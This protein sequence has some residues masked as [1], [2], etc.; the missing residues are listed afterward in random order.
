MDMT[1]ILVLHYYPNMN[2]RTAPNYGT[3]NVV[4][5][6]E[7]VVA[8]CIKRSLSQFNN[9]HTVRAAGLSV[10]TSVCNLPLLLT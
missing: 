9:E 2:Y 5:D 4:S 3:G 7:N 10:Q 8:I 1:F 6:L